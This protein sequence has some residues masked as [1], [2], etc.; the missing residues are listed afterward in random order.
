MNLPTQTFEL[1]AI[2]A[3]IS[4]SNPRV[5]FTNPEGSAQ[6]G[7]EWLAQFSG[8]GF[9]S[10]CLLTVQTL[11]PYL[12]GLALNRGVSERTEGFLHGTDPN[13]GRIWFEWPTEDGPQPVQ[14]MDPR[15]SHCQWRHIPQQS[16][17]P[18]PWHFSQDPKM[19]AD[20][21]HVILDRTSGGQTWADLA[22][23]A[24]NVL[25]GSCLLTGG[26]T[27]M[28]QA[29]K[30]ISVF[31]PEKHWDVRPI[32]SSES[33]QILGESTWVRQVLRSWV[34]WVGWY[35]TSATEVQAIGT[36]WKRCPL[37]GQL[38]HRWPR[39][40]DP[41]NLW[42]A[43]STDLG[44]D[45]LLLVQGSQEDLLLATRSMVPAVTGAGR[46]TLMGLNSV[47]QHLTPYEAVLLAPGALKE[48]RYIRLL[49]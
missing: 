41:N 49:L 32:G 31:A 10:A 7:S 25:E 12:L 13:A 26:G 1:A 5:N 33:Y 4:G 48:D 46:R 40:L 38:H 8:S 36:G 22:A 44:S 43:A 24:M 30:R 15:L 42:I 37:P 16:R 2:R 27:V 28:T 17:E 35:L 11:L 19:V 21:L 20:W 47:C 6:Q 23:A 39:D 9:K 18:L 3:A 34:G 45:L 14:E 29:T